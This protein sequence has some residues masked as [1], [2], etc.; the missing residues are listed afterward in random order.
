MPPARGGGAAAAVAGAVVAAAATVVAAARRVAHAEG[1]G[2]HRQRR[3]VV[4]GLRAACGTPGPAA[5]P[6]TSSQTHS[7][8]CTLSHPPQKALRDS[9]HGSLAKTAPCNATPAGVAGRPAEHAMELAACRGCPRM[10]PAT[11][12]CSATSSR[13]CCGAW[14]GAGAGCDA[15]RAAQAVVQRVGGRGGL[16]G[17][18]RSRQGVAALQVRGDG[19]RRGHVLVLQQVLV[20]ACH[21]LHVPKGRR[22]ESSAPAHTGFTTSTSCECP[23]P[24][25]LLVA[26]CSAASGGVGRR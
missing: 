20:G 2:G 19:Q 25:A 22:L 5:I 7:A 26:Q 3:R 6:S 21:A 16:A 4:K 24:E 9:D 1:H 13:G 12:F 10:Q 17:R 18:V 23:G 11:M 8:E 15:H 14:Q